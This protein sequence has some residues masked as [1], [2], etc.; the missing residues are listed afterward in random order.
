M[1]C[2]SPRPS[3]EK[4]TNRSVSSISWIENNIFLLAHTPSNFGSNEAPSSVFH[5]VTRESPSS[6]LYQKISEPAGPFGLNR[7][8]PHHFFL[9]LKEFPPN[10]QD[11]I[12]VAST[13]STDIGVFT[14]AKVPLAHDKP[15]N[16]FAMTEMSDD[17]RRAQLP[18]T[19]ELTDTS[20]IGMA[21][22]LSSKD[23]VIKPIPSDE[24][25]ASQ[26]PLPALMVLNNEGVLASW[27]IVYSD[28]VRQGTVYP[29]LAVAESA[30]QQPA[31]AHTQATT[32]V[33]GG[34]TK[35]AFG[36]PSGAFGAHS[37]LGQNQSP[38]TSPSA[39]ASTTSA[40][41]NT[42]GF[43]APS[44]PKP[45]FNTSVFGAPSTPAFGTS[46]FS[47][48][49]A[50]PWG[51]GASTTTTS[52]FGQSSGLGKPAGVFGSAAPAT[53]AAVPTSG[54][55]ASFASKGGFTA[56]T[57]APSAGSVLGGKASTN[58]FGNPS[59]TSVFG[60][61][62]TFGGT[63]NKPEQKP[64]GIFGDGSSSSGFVLESTFKADP[65]AKND[66]QETTSEPKGLFFGGTLA[67]ALGEATKAPLHESESK[68]AEMD[69]SEDIAKPEELIKSPVA[70]LVSTPATTTSVFASTPPISSLS[71][72][73]LFGRVSQVATATTAKPSISASFSF[74][75]PLADDDKAAARVSFGKLSVEMPAAVE[76]KGSLDF[77]S[78]TAK[79][80]K[81]EEP[82]P[83]PITFGRLSME[84][85]KSGSL[86][87]PKLNSEKQD[88]LSVEEPQPSPRVKEEP[89]SDDE[90]A[91][92]KSNIDE[93]PLPPDTTS[94]PYYAAGDTSVSSTG[95]DAPLPPDFI[96]KAALKESPPSSTSEATI[97][98][99][100]SADLIPPSEV[101]G[102]PDDDGHESE[103][104]EGNDG[105]ESE[106]P[107]EEEGL[108]E[109]EEGEEEEQE[110]SGEDVAKDLSPAS[111]VNET[112]GFTPQSSF[113]ALNNRTPDSTMFTKI[114]KPG[115]INQNRS[116]FG[117]LAAPVLLPPKVPASPRSP[118]P[119]RSALPGRML[120][121]E[122]SRSV[123]A[124]GIASQ[125]LGSQRLSRQPAGQPSTFALTLEQQK[126][127]EQRRTKARALRE[128]AEKQALVDNEDEDLQR[129]L[130]SE[131]VATTTLDEF[132][133]HSNYIGQTSVDSIP[134][135]VE[136]VYRDINSM[137]DTLGLNAR[138][139]KCFMK[140]HTEQ[141]KEG[142]RTKR[143][144]ENEDDWCL[145]EIEDLTED[146][147]N[148]LMYE[149][150]ESRLQDIDK[151]LEACHE[152]QKDLNRLRARHEDIKKIHAA[153]FDPDVLAVARA[154]PLNTEQ[155]AQQHDLRR[156][157]T[158]FQ[159]LLAEAEEGLTI[160]KA[161]IASQQVSHGRFGT[162]AVPTVEAVM[163]TITKMTS[164][165]ERRSGDIDMLEGQMRKLRFDSVGSTG[166]REGSPFTTPHNSRTSIRNPG[167]A[168]TYGLFYTPDSIRDTT[169]GGFQDSLMSSTGSFSRNSPPRKKLS[170][171]TAEEK[172][173]L[174]TKLANKKMVTDRLRTALQKAGTNVRLMD[175]DEEKFW[176]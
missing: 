24:M 30:Q 132:V 84:Q 130:A 11:V 168:S 126:A 81:P 57:A 38:W 10:L 14:R 161:K 108:G 112:P 103:L 159:N 16:A 9:R 172:N 54:G 68:D 106:G 115:Q 129:F 165:A 73:G 82:K 123:S 26:T 34:A 131:P 158:K 121:A 114:P 43:G 85:P 13:A 35:P 144:L 135:Q 154:Q 80:P 74:G 66:V 47:G 40:G 65:A 91:S 171:Y 99:P 163:R 29:G 41:F 109:E 32:S 98:K 175:D 20:P 151:K 97:K 25:D 17:S 39:V 174:R 143:D 8:P 89:V 140:G 116:L 136:T 141:R 62:S 176:G 6:F 4:Q 60:S 124:P 44:G 148:T 2:D 55:F 49:K 147:E 22:D 100:I 78:S 146:V 113:G 170:G 119:V 52:V 145:V 12:I 166:S 102:G 149:L 64:A 127:E 51:S 7:S 1:V 23:K 56:A 88:K 142:G 162:G 90:K 173:Q 153:R 3:V 157:F 137:I 138:T 152:L 15:A 69:I 94:K 71:T 70:E 61:S 93:A 105:D 133:A 118:S 50:S 125:I 155:A 160:L 77:V 75:K 67:S 92:T 86:T 53:G 33:F 37:G 117:E 101:P 96:P 31:S 120:R 21:L 110:G 36:A 42:P 83:A 104:S 107:S 134:A 45:A 128:A 122:S 164:M 58:A 95:T 156:D 59:T 87:F 72:G 5:I 48:P 28:S 150:E 18:M 63:Q 76:P 111:E 169:R 46:G 19:G 167:T 79:E 27:W 139:L